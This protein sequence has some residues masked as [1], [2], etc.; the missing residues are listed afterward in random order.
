MNFL[1]EIN[2]FS[3]G[4]LHRHHCAWTTGSCNKIFVRILFIFNI[5]DIA[6][7]EWIS[8]DFVTYKGISTIARDNGTVQFTFFFF[9]RLNII[10]VT[11]CAMFIAI[12]FQYFF[13]TKLENGLTK[14]VPNINKKVHNGLVYM[15]WSILVVNIITICH[16]CCFNYPKEIMEILNLISGIVLKICAYDHETI[17]VR[18]IVPI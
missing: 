17:I 7:I 4:T 16:I 13:I 2:N 5:C 11:S 10:I 8:H 18:I 3:I 6:F 9:M 12:F 1:G 14:H 15:D